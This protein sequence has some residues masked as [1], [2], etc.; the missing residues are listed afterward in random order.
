MPASGPLTD[1]GSY[2]VQEALPSGDTETFGAAG[3]T[4]AA[5][6]GNTTGGEN[7]ANFVNFTISGTKYTDV[8]GLD[9]QTAIGGDDTVL[10]GVTINL[11]DSTAPTTVI[12]TTTT[13]ANGTYSFAGLGPLTDGG[14]YFV[15]EALPSGDTETFGA[16]G[17]TVAATSGNTTG[18]E[19]F[20]NFV[21]FDHLRHEVH[22]RQWPGQPDC[23]WR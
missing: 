16:A 3:H 2:F 17:H 15:Q 10:G 4:V 13:A 19:N 5:T 8:N 18:G 20:A 1:G 12:A 9:N 21:N 14:S 7:S 11:Y 23:H 6:S 22:R